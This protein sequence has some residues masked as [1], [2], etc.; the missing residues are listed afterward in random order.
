MCVQNVVFIKKKIKIK[1]NDKCLRKCDMNTMDTSVMKT[2]C[3]ECCE[4]KC[5]SWN[6]ITCRTIELLL[7][8]SSCE[9]GPKTAS[10]SSEDAASGTNGTWASILYGKGTIWPYRFYQKI[11]SM[12]ST[13]LPI[14]K[15]DFSKSI[16]IRKVYLF[17]GGNSPIHSFRKGIFS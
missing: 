2:R 14:I 12:Q 4:Q 10:Q 9:V 11:F 15:K 1:Q 17:H 8:C 13:L 6:R 5:V 7:R 3:N 16:L